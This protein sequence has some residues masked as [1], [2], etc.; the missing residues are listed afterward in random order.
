MP[1]D[2]L[3]TEIMSRLTEVHGAS[4]KGRVARPHT[5]SNS[6]IGERCSCCS[7]DQYAGPERRRHHPGHR[8]RWRY[9]ALSHREGFGSSRHP[10]AA[11]LDLMASRSG[12]PGY[13]DGELT[14][15][16]SKNL[17]IAIFS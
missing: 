17:D 1:N 2:N 7:G 11:G 15:A 8:A 12:Q 5:A 3:I 13:D 9:E 10:D 16:I 4:A 14:P 6:M